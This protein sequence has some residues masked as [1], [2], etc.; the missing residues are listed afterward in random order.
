MTKFTDTQLDIIARTL[1]SGRLGGFAACLGDA[2]SIADTENT[3][4]LVDAFGDI[5]YNALV[6]DA[7]FAA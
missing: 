1:R 5:F 7:R 2:L 3:Q 6:L 4:K